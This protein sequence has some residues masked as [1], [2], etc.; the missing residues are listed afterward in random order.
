MP[1]RRRLPS[2]REVFPGAP[3]PGR[4][5]DPGLFGPSSVAWRVGRER[6]L[7]AGGPAALLMQ[8]AHPLVAAGV[9]AHSDF[10]ADPL[11]RLRGTMGTTLTVRVRVLASPARELAGVY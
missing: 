10:E 6:L 9:S 1:S 11:R 8:V 3:A 7:L 2:A 4:A 5:G